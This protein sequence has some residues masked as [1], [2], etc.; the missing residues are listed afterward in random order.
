MKTGSSPLTQRALGAQVHFACERIP[1]EQQRYVRPSA[2]RVVSG[3]RATI[4]GKLRP[5]IR[6]VCRLPRLLAEAT[7][8]PDHVTLYA[9][10]YLLQ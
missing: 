4:D 3:I 7:V 6:K 10:T 1:L 8:S 9:A 5:E 2:L